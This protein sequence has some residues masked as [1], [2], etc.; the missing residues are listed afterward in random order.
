[1]STPLSTSAM[2]DA[3]TAARCD[4]TKM[5]R[6]NFPGEGRTWA[7]LVEQHTTAAWE[8]FAAL[9]T[10]HGYLFRESA[11]GTY[12]CRVIAGTSSYSLHSYGLCI[13]LNPS[14]NPHRSPLTTDIPKA[15]RADVASIVTVSGRQVFQWGGEWATPDAMHFQIGATPSELATGLTYPTT[16]EGGR[17]LLPLKQGQQSEDVEWLQRRLN[18]IG[19][20]LTPDGSY[21]PATTKAVK[22]LLVTG[23]GAGDVVTGYLWNQLDI[24]IG[25]K[26]DGRALDDRRA[27]YGQPLVAW[28]ATLGIILAI[29]A[30]IISMT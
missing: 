24:K 11:G 27:Y 4:T 28:V 7:L 30:V 12:N 9:M 3:Y 6:V 19:A 17:T 22:T 25:A 20:D 16:I 10:S 29:I 2:R 23:N 21:G 8:A 26:G 5:V 15:F 18:R 14:K 13:D 1:M